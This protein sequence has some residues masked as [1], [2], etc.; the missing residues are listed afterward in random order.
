M[1]SENSLRSLERSGWSRN[2]NIDIQK[3][4]EALEEEGYPVHES[5]IQCL[6]SFSN[7][8]IWTSSDKNAVDILI[9]PRAAIDTVYIER[10]TEEYN[11]IA[12]KEL[13]V[14]GLYHRNHMVL[15]LDDEGVVYGGYD[16]HFSCLAKSF[17]NFLNSKCT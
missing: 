12:E 7:L 14:I 6:R 10:I 15:M 4:I 11:L 9:D 3:Q 2:R 13:C 5:V 17:E 1:L 16:E 8:K